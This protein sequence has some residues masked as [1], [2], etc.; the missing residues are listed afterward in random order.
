MEH[1]LYVLNLD[2]NKQQAE[3]VMT[4]MPCQIS[5]IN[6]MQDMGGILLQPGILSC[7]VVLSIVRFRVFEEKKEQLHIGNY[8]M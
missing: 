1:I 5:G 2:G 6:Y 7:S 4:I 3:D 8:L